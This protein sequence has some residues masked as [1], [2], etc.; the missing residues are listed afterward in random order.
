MVIA[1]GVLWYVGDKNKREQEAKKAE[2]IKEFLAK[3]KNIEAVALQDQSNQGDTNS[4]T[5]DL[6]IPK[7]IVATTTKA[8]STPAQLRAYSLAL[9]EA[10]TPLSAPRASEPEAVLQAI[11]NNEA[12]FLKPVTTSRIIHDKTLNNLSQ[13]IVPK[14]LV[15]QHEAIVSKMSL[16]VGQLTNMEK[17]LDQPRIALNNSEAFTKSYLEFVRLIG[18]LETFLSSQG[19]PINEQGRI[20]IFNSFNQVN[21]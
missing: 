8:S 2:Y 18:N 15:K 3:Q 6:N 13:I 19:L 7:T 20:R 21:Q 17:T 12:S 4:V 16:F 14:E 9:A 5:V 11:S 1:I 10:L